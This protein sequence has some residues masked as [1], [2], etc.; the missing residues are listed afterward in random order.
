MDKTL[1]LSELNLLEQY[2][3][4]QIAEF[5][6][7]GR[8]CYVTNK[9]FAEWTKY[10]LSQI[11][12]TIKNLESKHVIMRDTIKFPKKKMRVLSLYPRPEWDVKFKEPEEESESDN[13]GVEATINDNG[14]LNMNSPSDTH[15]VNS[16][17]TSESNRNNYGIIDNIE[18]DNRL[19]KDNST[20]DGDSTANADTNLD[21]SAYT[22]KFV[23]QM[24]EEKCIELSKELTRNYTSSEGMFYI[25]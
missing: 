6:G 9:Q 11:E 25:E 22:M 18:K 20:P 23:S 19:E 14:V 1:R 13:G 17:A 4:C 12:K 7:N 24:S 16:T 15:T 21:T 5:I 3:V 2:I 10:S 8:E